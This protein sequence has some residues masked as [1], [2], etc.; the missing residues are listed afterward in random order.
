[1]DKSKITL[2]KL[3][4][5]SKRVES[6]L[7]QYPQYRD[8]DIKLVAH[9]WMEQLG[10][11]ENMGSVN[12]LEWMRFW[13]ENQNSVASPENIARARRKI[14][15]NDETLRGENYKL[16]KEQ[17]KSVRSGIKDL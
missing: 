10:G 2:N 15:E 8:C 17:E 11:V 13:I 4:A 7:K 9:I 14:Q 5:M 6:L 1:M 3:K 12:L 16:R